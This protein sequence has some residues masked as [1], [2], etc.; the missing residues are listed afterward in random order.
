MMQKQM[1]TIDT[2]NMCSHLQNKA[3]KCRLANIDWLRIWAMIAVVFIH[4]DAFYTYSILPA[5]RFAVPLYFMIAGYFLGEHG[6]RNYRKYILT[7]FKVFI[8][9]TLFYG[10]VEIAGSLYNHT[11]MLEWSWGKILV[12]WMLF[13]VNPF[14]YHLWFLGAYLYVLCIAALVDNLNLWKWMYWLIIPLLIAR[15]GLQCI[16]MP[17]FVTRNFLFIGLPCFLVGSWLRNNSQ[18]YKDFLSN[19]K[20][21]V[22]CVL[23]ACLPFVEDY[24]LSRYIGVQY[25]DFCTSYIFAAL[26]LVSAV[27]LPQILPQYIPQ[28]TRDIVLGVYIFH[29]FVHFV[30]RHI[31][32][33]NEWGSPDSWLAPVIVF[34][35]TW[36]F[37]VIT[38]N[39]LSIIK[40][41][42]I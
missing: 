9:A 10:A 34:I 29:P 31:P 28:Y 38:L 7:A 33:V 14:H 8:G 13:N 12:K 30:Y 2:T 18:M 6:K 20:I 27:E 26:L 15:F 5:T 32:V 1:K 16:D 41:N 40:Q 23:C 17:A 24:C 25:G 4:I 22:A 37:C 42:K 11:S 21:F 36:V 35:T 39:I 3:K 19:R